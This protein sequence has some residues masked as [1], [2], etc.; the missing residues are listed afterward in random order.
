MEYKTKSQM[1]EVIQYNESNSLY[2][3]IKSEDLIKF[4]SRPSSIELAVES[5]SAMRYHGQ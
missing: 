3:S 5:Y 4:S 1:K 2:D